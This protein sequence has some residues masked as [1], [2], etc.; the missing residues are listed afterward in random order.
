VNSLLGNYVRKGDNIKLQGRTG[1][2][3]NWSTRCASGDKD[4]DIGMADCGKGHN[5]Q[6][7]AIWRIQT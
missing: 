4:R 2:L 1:Y 5:V 3:D 7:N 6:N